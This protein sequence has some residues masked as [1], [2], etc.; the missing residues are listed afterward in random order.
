MGMKNCFLLLA[1]AAVRGRTDGS[2]AALGLVL[3]E[4]GNAREYPG[5]IW[6]RCGVFVAKP[7]E[8]WRGGM[9]GG[10]KIFDD[11]ER[12]TIWVK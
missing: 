12:E 6:Y 4:Q 9:C 7:P 3:V 2:R 1:S 5:K 11:S 10:L 8:G